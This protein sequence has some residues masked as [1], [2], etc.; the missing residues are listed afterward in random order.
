[1]VEAAEARFNAALAQ[2]ISQIGSG[3]V[4]V[5]SGG[6]AMGKIGRASASDLQTGSAFNNKLTADQSI[7]S[8]TG[9]MITGMGTIIA[10]SY[11]KEAGKR[12][13]EA[14]QQEALGTAAQARRDGQNEIV[15]TM[16]DVLR[17]IR[18]QLRA[19]VQSEIE[20]NRGMARNI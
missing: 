14:K 19:M 17:D 12:D 16:G 8:G 3:V 6:V 7:S 5:A 1:M 11:E 9:Q 15:Q 18:E 4:S 10:G 20:T 2:G 13:A